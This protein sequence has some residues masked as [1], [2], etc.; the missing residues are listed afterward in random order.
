MKLFA[1][2]NKK[3]PKAAQMIGDT[4]L[5]VGTAAGVAAVLVPG[6]PVL[7]TIAAV[8]G[9]VTKIV[10]KFFAEDPSEKAVKTS[11]IIKD[12]GEIISEIK[13]VK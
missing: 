2:W 1:N 3:T 13:S 12:A 4:A 11:E 7:L 9:G 6:I 5:V 10:T 8:A